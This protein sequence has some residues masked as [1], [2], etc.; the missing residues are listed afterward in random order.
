M[1]QTLFF[2]TLEALCY[3]MAPKRSRLREC[4][5][6]H[7]RGKSVVPA[8]PWSPNHWCSA[9]GQ[10]SVTPS[11]SIAEAHGA[12]KDWTIEN[13]VVFFLRGHVVPAQLVPLFFS[14]T[15]FCFFILHLAPVWL[16]K[17]IRL[18]PE[19]VVPLGISWLWAIKQKVPFGPTLWS[20]PTCA[21]GAYSKVITCHWVSSLGPSVAATCTDF[22]SAIF[23]NRG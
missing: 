5:W 11:Q 14:P 4:A 7:V 22:P 16:T 2:S 12:S 10:S 21:I 6:R 18:Q 1:C 9:P 8:E 15:F 3:P 17:P 13:G 23:L 20:K 19:T